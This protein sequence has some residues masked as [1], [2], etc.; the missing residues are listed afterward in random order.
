MIDDLTDGE[1]NFAEAGCPGYLAALP[2]QPTKA[3][4]D[5]WNKAA[6][7][8]IPRS[9]ATPSSPSTCARS[10]RATASGS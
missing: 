7:D 3:Y 10:S 4:W 2:K 5:N 6:A 8:A 9:T 1:G